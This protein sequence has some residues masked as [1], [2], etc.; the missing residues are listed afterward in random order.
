MTFD[1]TSTTLEV[2]SDLT[3]GLWTFISSWNLLL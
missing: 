3:S 2:L 1:L